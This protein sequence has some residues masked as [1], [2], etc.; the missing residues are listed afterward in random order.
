MTP[1]LGATLPRL[2]R[3]WAHPSHI[4]TGT[5]L[6]PPTSAPGLGTPQVEH[7]AALVEH[8]I[9]LAGMSPKRKCAEVD[10]DSDGGKAVP[11]PHVCVFARVRTR[12]SVSRMAASLY[13][14]RCRL[15]AL[16]CLLR[17]RESNG[18]S[19]RLSLVP[20]RPR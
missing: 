7:G 13:A 9:L 1:G 4:C 14:F 15:G 20:V 3:D 10:M 8:A 5:G 19:A 17:W 6:T 12:A 18:P 11:P 2:H 16:R